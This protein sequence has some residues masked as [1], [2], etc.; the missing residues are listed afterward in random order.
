[1]NPPAQTFVAR[2]GRFAVV[3][4]VTAALVGGVGACV[5]GSESISA[6]LAGCSVSWVS[7]CAGAIPLAVAAGDAPQK[8]ANAVLASTAV[9]FLV[10]LALAAPLL[11]GGWFPGKP[12]TVSLGVSYLVLLTVDSVMGLRMLREAERSARA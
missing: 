4:F 2:F 1:M 10:V 3:G 8:I 12:L 6:V 11:L 5:V 7:S 9:R